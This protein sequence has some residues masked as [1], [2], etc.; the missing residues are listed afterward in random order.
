MRRNIPVR[1]PIQS[2]CIQ[3]CKLLGG[4]CTGCKRTKSEISV[5]YSLTDE[6]RELKMHEL[7]DRIFPDDDPHDTS[8]SWIL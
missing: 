2:P 3:K 6:Q 8:I 1:K 4:M 7:K 5:W